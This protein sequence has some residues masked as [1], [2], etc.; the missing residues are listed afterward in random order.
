MQK[1]SADV[2]V[3]DEE[4]TPFSRAGIQKVREEEKMDVEK[5]NLGSN[6]ISKRYVGIVKHTE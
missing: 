4:C 3:P 5:D 6:N 1:I 2:E